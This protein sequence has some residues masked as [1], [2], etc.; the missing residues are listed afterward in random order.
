MTTAATDT[1]CSI[2]TREGTGR[3]RAGHSWAVRCSCGQWLGNADTKRM[4]ESLQ[5]PKAA[6]AR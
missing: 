3:H 1:H 6:T 4:G 2:A 5:C